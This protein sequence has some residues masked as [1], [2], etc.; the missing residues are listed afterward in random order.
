MPDKKVDA[1]PFQKK[2]MWFG[3]YIAAGAMVGGAAIHV[4]Y[5]VGFVEMLKQPDF[6]ILMGYIW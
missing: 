5:Y 3:N 2:V 4:F 6:L 1:T